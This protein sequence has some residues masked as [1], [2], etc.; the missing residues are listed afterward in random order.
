MSEN[1]AT[2]SLPAKGGSSARRVLGWLRRHWR[3]IAWDVAMV[4]LA[5]LNLGL[6][7]FDFT[8][9]RLRPFY[10][11]HLGLVVR[12]YDPVKG[13]EPNPLT[14]RYVELVTQLGQPGAGAGRAALLDELR[15]LGREALDQAPFVRVGQMA[16]RRAFDQRLRDFVAARDGLDRAAL[17]PHQALDL[18]WRPGDDAE[19][20][21]SVAFFH[22]DLEPLLEVNFFRAYDRDGNFV[23][24]GWLIDLPFLL[25]FS[26]EFYGRWLLAYRRRQ[27]A[28][29]WIYPVLHWYDFLGIMP[30]PQ[31]RVFRLFRIGSL[32]VRLRRS[33][34]SK[35][36][37]DVVSRLVGQVAHMVTEEVTHRVAIRILSASQAALADGI[38]G[39]IT[40]AVL[41]PRRDLLIRELTLAVE[42]AVSAGETR[43]AARTFVDEVLE[44]AATSSNGLRHLPLPREVL[45][46]IVVAVGRVVFD[47]L[48]EA[49]AAT[50]QDEEGRRALEVVLGDV[51]DSVLDELTSGA[52]EKLA[53]EALVE[54]LDQVKSAVAVRDWA[55]K[56]G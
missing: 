19:L 26:V 1:E 21:T 13:I 24:H 32:Y 36:G 34:H 20:A 42:R 28:E 27:Y 45:Q 23:D 39:R 25:L 4:Q 15:R 10:L 50:L 51:V 55:E 54:T 52:G 6:L 38:Q 40:R 16:E 47:S 14:V 29:W 2:G 53:R 30:L 31:F 46:P 43:A 17:S 12:V 22:R 5:L 3:T 33:E 8:Y 7:A 11:R 56:G 49:L 37:D 18:L 41:E 48:F 44:Q 9:L 35:V